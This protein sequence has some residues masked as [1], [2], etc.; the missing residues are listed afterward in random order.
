MKK[1]ILN[2]K[3]VQKL[4]KEQQQTI[5][6]GNSTSVTCYDNYFANSTGSQCWVVGQPG[7][8]AITGNRCCFGIVPTDK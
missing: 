1:N 6:G 8:G 3:G 5:T 2:L 7:T 4:D